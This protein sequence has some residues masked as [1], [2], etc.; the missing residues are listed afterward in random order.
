[1]KKLQFNHEVINELYNYSWGLHTTNV[2]STI[3]KL[4]RQSLIEDLTKV[5]EDGITNFSAYEKAV[6]V[7]K[8]LTW[9]NVGFVQTAVHILAEIKATEAKDIVK[10]CLYQNEAFNELYLMEFDSEEFPQC[11][12]RTVGK[13]YDFYTEIALNDSL[14]W[15]SRATAMS[16]MSQIV[17]QGIDEESNVLPYFRKSIEILMDKRKGKDDWDDDNIMIGYIAAALNDMKTQALNDVMKQAFNLEVVDESICGNYQE[18]LEAFEEYPDMNY[19]K[20][21]SP[22]LQFYKESYELNIKLKQEQEEWIAE[23]VEQ[24]NQEAERLALIESQKINLNTIDTQSEIATSS[25]FQYTDKKVG[26]NE[27]CPCGSGKKYK[28]CHGKL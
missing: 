21:Y 12:I 22:L 6:E 9:Q 17:I 16:V 3:L 18:F 4:P 8:T 15:I 28:K 20:P 26:R 11:L 24:E 13:D 1:M 10:K 7:D 25:S 19:T 27:P 14:Y 2:L 23:Q 5:I